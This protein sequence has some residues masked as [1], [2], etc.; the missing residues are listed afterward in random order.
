MGFFSIERFVSAGREPTTSPSSYR[1]R[2]EEKKCDEQIRTSQRR[3]TFVQGD[4]QLSGISRWNASKAKSQWSPIDFCEDRWMKGTKK[5][6]RRKKKGTK[7]RHDEKEEVE[8]EEEVAMRAWLTKGHGRA[9]KPSRSVEFLILTKHS[10]HAGLEER[11]RSTPSGCFRYSTKDN[12]CHA[13][14]STMRGFARLEQGRII[15]RSDFHSTNSPQSSSG[16]R[17][18]H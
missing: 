4:F 10:Q 3:S 5:E 14:L 7:K 15:Y 11:E 1:L 16:R 17:G 18:I 2:S 6:E 9:E 8:V 12:I 13:Y